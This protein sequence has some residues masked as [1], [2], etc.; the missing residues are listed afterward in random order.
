[1]RDDLEMFPLKYLHVSPSPWS[2]IYSDSWT[3]DDTVVN[4]G[5]SEPRTWT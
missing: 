2:N 1:M 4:C 5:E 3:G